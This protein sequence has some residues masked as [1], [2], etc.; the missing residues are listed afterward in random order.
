MH[1]GF[2][3]HVGYHAELPG[4]DEILAGTFIPHPDTDPY[5]VK[6]LQQLKM[7]D[8]VYGQNILKAIT[9]ESYQESWKRMKPNTSSS[10]S[11]PSFVD[12]TAGSRNSQIANFTMANIPYA[13]SYNPEV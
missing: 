5:T 3:Q 8:S 13:S 1:P 2:V 7:Q 4:A 6:F 12:D 9:T 11:G 10:P